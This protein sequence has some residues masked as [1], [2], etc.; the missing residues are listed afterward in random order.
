MKT[1]IRENISSVDRTIRIVIGT[2]MCMSILVM[3][4][5]SA[6]IASFAF[7]AMY[8]LLSGLTAVDPFLAVVNSISLKPVVMNKSARVHTTSFGHAV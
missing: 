8:P 3:P 2:L 1:L 6:W 7:A 5:N 4:Y